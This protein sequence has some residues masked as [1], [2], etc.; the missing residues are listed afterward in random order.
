MNK[1]KI[2]ISLPITGQPIVE[3]RK[4]A[5]AVKTEMSKRGHNVIT[6]FDV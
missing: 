1:K 4:K 2:Y 3:A 5:Q 6:P